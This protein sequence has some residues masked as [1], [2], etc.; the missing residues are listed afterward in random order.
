M[1]ILYCTLACSPVK[2]GN[3][4]IHGTIIDDSTLNGKKAYLTDYGTYD[5]I[6]SCVI[7]GDKF[8]FSGDIGHLTVLRIDAE[9]LYANLIADEGV[10]DVLLYSN[11]NDPY[12][13][14]GTPLNDQMRAYEKERACI[15]LKENKQNGLGVYLA[16]G[17]L[18]HNFSVAQ[19]D[20]VLSDLSEANRSFGV[21]TRW[22]DAAVN[23]E[24][25]GTGKM[26]L[27]FEGVNAEGVA[28]K[29]SDFVGRGH[30][31]LIDF[32]ASWCGPCR[33]EI[34][35]IK[36]IYAENRENGLVVLGINVWD[37][38]A[39]FE[40]A[41]KELE[42]PWGQICLFND[43]TALQKYGID[44]VPQIILFAPDGTIIA[45]NLNGEKIKA[46]IAAIYAK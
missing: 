1:T 18:E 40:K 26:F 25:T 4:T 22:R 21:F 28:V 10:T 14:S 33:A 23:R 9:D 11:Y 42:M 35:I 43:E 39:D 31:V 17:K 6:D 2:T 37:E 12:V 7:E 8:S 30:Y 44:G 38:K 20:S 45:R 34:P 46:R 41:M 3:Y 15:S 13:V 29:L 24:L 36:K 16:W 19:I 5:I 27:D 32:W